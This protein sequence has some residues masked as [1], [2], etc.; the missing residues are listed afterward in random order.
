MK[1]YM[2]DAGVSIN[3]SRNLF[4]GRTIASRLQARHHV[5]AIIP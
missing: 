1:G 5:P 3:Y 4:G 2:I